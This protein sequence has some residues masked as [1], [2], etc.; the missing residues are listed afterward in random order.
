MFAIWIAKHELDF[1][2]ENYCMELH[3]EWE[4]SKTS[5]DNNRRPA[6]DV[7]AKNAGRIINL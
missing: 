6:I 7:A 3:F 1:Q 2:F 4:K 5:T